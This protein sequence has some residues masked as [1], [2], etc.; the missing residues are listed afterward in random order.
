MA[1]GV[2]DH[3]AGLRLELTAPSPPRAVS[4]LTQITIGG[5]VTIDGGAAC[6][7]PVRLTAAPGGQA[8]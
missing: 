3:R 2:P 8:D 5:Q 1:P 7:P 4:S 6:P